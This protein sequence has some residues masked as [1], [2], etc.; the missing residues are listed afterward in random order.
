MHLEENK[1][2]DKEID[3]PRSSVIY[4]LFVSRSQVALETFF[5]AVNHVSR[6][7]HSQCT[8]FSCGHERVVC[9]PASRRGRGILAGDAF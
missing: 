3:A 8:D 5:G 7:V 1:F 9:G 6:V 2:V 4:K